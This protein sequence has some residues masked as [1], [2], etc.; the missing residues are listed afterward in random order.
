MEII[1]RITVDLMQPDIPTQ[2]HAKQ[3]DSA[4]FVEVEL[5]DRGVA[6]AL[7][8]GAEA[9]FRCRKP[10]GH[11]CLNPAEISENGT[12]RV[13]L[14]A[15]ALA[16]PGIVQAD[17]SLLGE[18]GKVLSSLNFEICVEAAPLGDLAESKDELGAYEERLEQIRNAAAMS[19]ITAF[20]VTE[21]AD[22]VTVTTTGEDGSRSVVTARFDAEGY[23]T[24]LE[25]NGRAIPGTWEVLA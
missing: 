23:P 14:T 4:R 17:V 1:K 2:I 25:V 13:E 11:S 16:V 5:L 12:V 3:G 10:D 7:P 8:E 15:Q 21:T 18:D 19:G 20:A 9:R 22:S 6:Y 24:T